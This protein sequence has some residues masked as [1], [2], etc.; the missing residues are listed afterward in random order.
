MIIE[1]GFPHKFTSCVKE[2]VSIVSYSLMMNK[3]LT[4]LFQ[5]RT[6][7]RQGNPMSPYP[8]VIAIENLHK[9]MT[10][11]ALKNSFT[12]AQDVKDLDSFTCALLIIY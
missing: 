1:L 8:F 11:M 10:Q 7:F 4:N 2:C 3:G 5:A 9:E 12:S 6:G